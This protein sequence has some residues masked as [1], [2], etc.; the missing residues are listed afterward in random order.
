MGDF[1]VVQ[2][3]SGG[4]RASV[5]L[6]MSNEIAQ[7]L[8]PPACASAVLLLVIVTLMVAAILRIVDVRKELAG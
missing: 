7:L 2:V 6:A 4:Q 1:F 5:V 3:M 8:Y